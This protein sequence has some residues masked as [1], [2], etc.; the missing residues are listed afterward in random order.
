MCLDLRRRIELIQDF[1]MPD[2]S[3]CIT[4]SKNRDYV[5]V[6]GTYKPRVK[7][8]D[9]NN[10]SMKFERCMDAE[11]LKALSLSDSYEK[12]SYFIYENTVVHNYREDRI[13]IF[14]QEERWVEFHVQYGRYFRFR[15]PKFGRDLN[16]NESNC[17]LYIVGSGNDIYRLNL[18]QGRFMT[19]FTS[20]QAA[21]LT[22][23]DLNNEHQLLM[24]G[25]WE[26]C[27]EA[28]DPRAKESVGILD[29]TKA[30]LTENIRF[31]QP[32]SISCIKFKD[33]LKLA[34]GTSSGQILMYDIRSN[35][36]YLLKDHNCDLAI[37][38]ID[39]CPNGSEPDLVLS[40]DR[41]MVK[42]WHENQNGKPYTTVEPGVDLNDLCLMKDTGLFFLANENQKV[43]TYYIPS[44]GPAPRWCAFLDNITEELEETEQPDVFLC[45]DI[46]TTEPNLSVFYKLPQ[47]NRELA[48]RLAQEEAGESK[49]SSTKKQK[50]LQKQSAAK[51]L[52]SD[53]R[54]K[55]LFENPD[56]QVDVET[57]EFRL[58]NP[59]LARL[60][61]QKSGKKVAKN[62]DAEED[63]N[64]EEEEHDEEAENG[65]LDGASTS[66]SEDDEDYKTLVRQTH[67]EVKERRR[68]LEEREEKLESLRQLKALKAKENK[69]VS[70]EIKAGE[71]FQSWAKE[72]S[73]P[74]K[75][76][77]KNSW[78]DAER[79]KIF[80]LSLYKTLAN[81]PSQR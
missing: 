11:P 3:N 73:K 59:A 1:D 38:C 55:Q 22:R 43:L 75:R 48:A 20:T 12:V 15:I 71:E 7:C 57:D 28:W 39:F 18:E 17:D 74:V 79:R 4:T 46:V 47:V 52:L 50:R 16:Y 62:S 77:N 56:F 49:S 9:V 41:R 34:V 60:E 30:L 32:P 40:M 24:C 69:P 31:G 8:Y 61:K 36:P 67:F 44:I 76:E 35:K 25:T 33:K 42:L 72:L 21:S 2:C 70:F 58:L 27:V 13:M 19:P 63:D 81:Q 29:I 37:K 65:E 64:G 23:C 51:T 10:L 45:L 78:S 26:G 14:L 5:F 66:S 53:D 6:C 68:L 80:G 54:F